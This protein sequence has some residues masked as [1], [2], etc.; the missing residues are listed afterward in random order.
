[1]K[2]FGYIVYAVLMLVAGY[3][4]IMVGNQAQILSFY[5]AEGS[6][7][8]ENSDYNG[9]ID[10][11]MQ[12]NKYFEYL[13]R[14]VY[15]GSSNEG[16]LPFDFFILQSNLTTKDF[17]GTLNHF[18][19]ID[20]LESYDHLFSDQESV[21]LFHKNSRLAFFVLEL[22]MEGEDEP[23]LTSIDIFIN[24]EGKSTYLEKVKS[25]PLALTH[26]H[27]ENNENYFRYITFDEEDEKQKA[28]WNNSKTI[29]KIDIHFADYTK[30]DANNPDPIRTKLISIVHNENYSLN[31]IDNF[32]INSEGIYESNG[33]NGHIDNYV[34]LEPFTVE[35]EV[36]VIFYD[37]LKSYRAVRNKWLVI[38]F[39]IAL[40]MTYV[41]FFLSPTLDYLKRKRFE[42][43][44]RDRQLRKKTAQ[45]GQI[46]LDE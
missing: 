32:T 25:K 20:H 37:S 45:D 16:D 5:N 4:F 22:Y 39:V 2:S 1:M 29:E 26:N 38:Y 28:I 14:P 21:D 6:K 34:N 30:T 7:A 15:H 12:Q 3:F 46:F 35:D 9:Y 10:V 13:D 24:D 31:N 42:K 44:Y 41:A 27:L 18:Y 36:R 43:K 17:S 19:F 11:F 23:T 8:L 40:F 33:F